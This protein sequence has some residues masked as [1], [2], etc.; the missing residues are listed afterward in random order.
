MERDP[1]GY[2]SARFLARALTD[3]RRRVR[4]GASIQDD[5]GGSPYALEG[6]QPRYQRDPR[7]SPEIGG[8]DGGSDRSG[9]G[10]AHWSG[11]GGPPA[12]GNG[13][14]GPPPCGHP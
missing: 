6:R 1:A 3:Y 14:E 4:A 11:T 12:G 5:E 10:T 9:V 2:A 7:A 8:S 13:R